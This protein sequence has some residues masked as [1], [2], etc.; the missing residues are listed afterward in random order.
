MIDDANRPKLHVSCVSWFLFFLMPSCQVSGNDED[1]MRPKIV[2]SFTNV[3]NFA[4][5]E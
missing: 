5:V 1:E 3:Y 2:K 4:Q